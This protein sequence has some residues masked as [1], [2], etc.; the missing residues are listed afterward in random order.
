MTISQF[1]LK[2][3]PNPEIKGLIPT[4]NKMGYMMENDDVFRK[5]FFNFCKKTPGPVLDIGAAYGLCSLKALKRG[6]KVIAND[7]DIRHLKILKKNIPKNMTHRLKLLHGKFPDEINFPKDHLGGVL[8]SQIFHFLNGEEI[9][10]SAEKIFKW[11]KPKGK[12]FIIASSPYIKLTKKY[13]TIYEKRKALG[14]KWPGF[15]ENFSKYSHNSKLK[16]LPKFVHLLDIKT[17]EEVF[18]QT[19]FII[20]KAINFSR[21]D[22]SDDFKLNGNENVGLIGI[23]P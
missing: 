6:A 10:N 8:A 16:N 20:E 3:A 7:I 4:L 2:Y 17:L 14:E 21:P 19:G 1:K 15:I 9:I 13:I 5:S 12:I 22:F 11:L 23:K 18:K